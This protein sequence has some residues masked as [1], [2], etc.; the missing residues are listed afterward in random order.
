M[1]KK[2]GASKL[3]TRKRWVR[4]RPQKE[5]V[6]VMSEEGGGTGGEAEKG[7]KN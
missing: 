1:G 4:N 6:Y 5:K 2:K 7:G 3:S